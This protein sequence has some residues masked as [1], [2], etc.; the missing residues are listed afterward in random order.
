MTSQEPLRGCPTCKTPV[1]TA[2]LGLRD[3]STWL[4]GALPGKV[5]ASDIDFVLEQA[6]TGRM[7]VQEFKEGSQPLGMGQRLLLK[8]MVRMGADVW[9]VNDLGAKGLKVGE[10]SPEGV[11]RFTQTMTSAGLKN[12]VKGWWYDGLS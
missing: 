10:L 11:V 2:Q 7:L 5:S 6:S 8:A 1:T 3:Y 4:D 9:V 12:A